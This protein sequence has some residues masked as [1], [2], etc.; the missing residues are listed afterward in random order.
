MSKLLN[1]LQAYR[2][3]TRV[4]VIKIAEDT[5]IDSQ[6][7]YRFSSGNGSLRDDDAIK[8]HG[9]LNEK[10]YHLAEAIECIQAIEASTS[11]GNHRMAISAR[12]LIEEYMEANK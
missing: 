11:G 7:L 8:L 5:K 4:P 10:S 6:R 2:E 3:R 1:R 9:Y 12:E